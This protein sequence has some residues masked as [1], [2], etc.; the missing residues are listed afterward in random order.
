MGCVAFE[1][2]DKN[3]IEN[4]GI[5]E[6]GYSVAVFFTGNTDRRKY[7]KIYF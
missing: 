7:D 1:S 3:H 2:H 4:L 5:F 6:N